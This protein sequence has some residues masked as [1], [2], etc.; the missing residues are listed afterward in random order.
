MHTN[1]HTSWKD[2]INVHCAKG[3]NE[4]PSIFIPLSC[5]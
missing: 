2:I 5:L 1:M 3:V 4:Q